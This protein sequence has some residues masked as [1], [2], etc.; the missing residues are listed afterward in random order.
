MAAI[1]VRHPLHGEMVCCSVQTAD[2]AKAN[3]WEE[4][5]PSAKPEPTVAEAPAV[6]PAKAPKADK[7]PN[8]ADVFNAIQN[9]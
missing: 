2:D 5:D 9:P 7:A 3:G 8:I 6:K 4:F 1:Y